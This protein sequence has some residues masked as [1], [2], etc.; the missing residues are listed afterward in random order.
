MFAEWDSFA[1]TLTLTY[2]RPVELFPAPDLGAFLLRDGFNL[3]TALSAVILP[4]NIVELS[5][6]APGAGTFLENV[7]YAPPPDSVRSIPGVPAV[8][9][10]GFALD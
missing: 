3:R 4:G 10:L 1:V 5:M 6:S 7:D 9:Q 2:D 8:E